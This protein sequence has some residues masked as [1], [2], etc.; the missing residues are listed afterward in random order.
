MQLDDLDYADDL[1]LLSHTQQQMQEKTNNVASLSAQ[2]GLIIHKGKTKI[3]KTNVANANAITLEGEA[4]EEV[5]AFT[6]LV[7][8]LT[9]RVAQTRTLEHGLEKCVQRWC[10]FE[11]SGAQKN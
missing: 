1:A 7:V 2:M 4:L 3:L 10:N 11:I 9:S 6:Y 8:L 5:E